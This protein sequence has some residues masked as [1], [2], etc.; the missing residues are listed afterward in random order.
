M[1]YALSS[2]TIYKVIVSSKMLKKAH[3]ILFVYFQA[4]CKYDDYNQHTSSIIA[5]IRNKDK[6][7]PLNDDKF[8]Q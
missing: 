6:Q 2:I 5:I 4:Y 8:L 1:E 7:Q 3:I